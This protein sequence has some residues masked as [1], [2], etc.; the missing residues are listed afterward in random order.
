MHSIPW[1]SI[2][3]PIEEIEASLQALRAEARTGY[4]KDEVRR[5]YIKSELV[6]Q[7]E[8]REKQAA[9]EAV[10]RARGEPSNDH[11]RRGSNAVGAAATGNGG[12][13]EV[14]EGR[15]F[16]DTPWADG[17]MGN[18]PQGEEGGDSSPSA[19][20][21]VADMAAA[22]QERLYPQLLAA[23]AGYHYDAAAAARLG[24]VREWD[25]A[26]GL[27][28]AWEEAVES[29]GGG[30]C[31]GGSDGGSALTAAA[32][33]G[34]DFLDTLRELTA[35]T[36]SALAAAA[37]ATAP[38][39][40]LIPTPPPSRS[41][42]LLP[43]PPPP[44]AAAAGA[45]AFASTYDL[46]RP[47]AAAAALVSTPSTAVTAAASRPRPLRIAG[48][49]SVSASRR[50]VPSITSGGSSITSGGGGGLQRHGTAVAVNYAQGFAQSAQRQAAS[51]R[52]QQQQQQKDLQ[53][54]RLEVQEEQRR[55]AKASRHRFPLSSGITIIRETPAAGAVVGPLIVSR[56]V[57]AVTLLFCPGCGHSFE[58]DLG[59]LGSAAGGTDTSPDTAVGGGD[60]GGTATTAAATVPCPGCG[61]GVDLPAS[62]SALL[63]P[64]R[65]PL[66]LDCDEHGRRIS[67]SSGPSDGGGGTGTDAV[68][69]PADDGGNGKGE[70]DD[71]S[72]AA[73]L[74]AVRRAMAA[75]KREVAA[76]TTTT[77]AITTTTSTGTGASCGTGVGAGSDVAATGAGSEQWPRALYGLY[78]LHLWDE[79]HSHSTKR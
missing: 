15:S 36:N 24:R 68:G 79:V 27:P 76:T 61:C 57:A 48:H 75:D 21:A 32:A 2:N 73:A 14:A 43:Q 47:A 5:S 7:R 54:L 46:R 64:R 9:A 78:F 11:T 72:F 42:S 39:Q 18:G 58:C 30:G 19:S 3:R 12:G 8:A 41:R 40:P 31:S 13:V 49:R 26:S 22:Q 34:G 77:T 38:V 53:N 69:F 33:V 52:R 60:G 17:D 59:R 63:P 66:E 35:G 74:A 1:A 51:H 16:L 56:V 45:A 55:A 37:T 10:V 29:T 71:G 23:A 67:S 44:A 62:G 4:G 25:G 28:A 20:T 65:P 6:A 70:G 50:S